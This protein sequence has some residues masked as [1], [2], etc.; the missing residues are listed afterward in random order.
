M[1]YDFL[2]LSLLCGVSGLVCFALRKDLRKPILFTA[3]ASVPFAFTESLFYPSY[4]EPRF[5]WN[6]ADKIGFGLE[7]IL[8]VM[9]LGALTV[10]AYPAVFGTTFAAPERRPLRPLALHAALVLALTGALVAIAVVIKAPMIYASVCIMLAMSGALIVIRSDLLVPAILGGA[11]TCAAYTLIC[12]LFS[13]LF[14]DVFRIVW[15]GE[16][17]SNVFIAGVLLEEYLYSFAAG[18]AGAIFYPF[19]SR[20]RFHEHHKNA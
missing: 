6:L 3:V 5:L 8:F 13:L 1:V 15:H 16:R 9:G 17:F 4:W 2:V 19:V 11:L 18:V 14:K 7:D 20:R 10:S 12:I